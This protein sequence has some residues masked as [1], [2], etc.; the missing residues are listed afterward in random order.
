M[1]MK[2]SVSELRQRLRAKLQAATDGARRAKLLEKQATINASAAMSGAIIA[3]P[4]SLTHLIPV[5]QL[6]VGA[7]KKT[8]AT[9][10]YLDLR[11]SSKIAAE[12][13]E[14]KFF[15]IIHGLIYTMAE[16]ILEYEGIIVGFRGDGLFAAF[17]LD[18]TGTC[19]NTPEATSSAARS[20][21]QCGKA[22][23][24]AVDN[25]L[26][27]ELR[28]AF[29]IEF[30][31]DAYCPPLTIGIGIDANPVVL[32]RIGLTDSNELT[33]YGHP[34]NKSCKLADDAAGEVY[35]TKGLWDLLGTEP[36]GRL[37]IQRRFS[38]GNIQDVH[39][40]EFPNDVKYLSE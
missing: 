26:I 33:A 39:C 3:G 21:V 40:I 8:W 15:M 35:V 10:L 32:T 20:A 13:S 28:D 34:V 17:G 25:V 29:A 24:E 18:E 5:A 22:L 12:V 9:V 2:R 37:R 38:V 31:N 6:D 27:P 23:L 14:K 11:Q 7:A 30:P 16:V 1:S 19:P 36:N 4:S